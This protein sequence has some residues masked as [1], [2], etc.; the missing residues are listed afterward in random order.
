MTPRQIARKMNTHIAQC[1]TSFLAHLVLEEMS[2]DALEARVSQMLVAESSRLSRGTLSS[3]G[4]HILSY[5]GR[6]CLKHFLE[7][8]AN[9]VWGREDF[10]YRAHHILAPQP[11]ARNSPT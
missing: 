10:S 2:P 3:V 9:I 11:E 4:V 8:K 1:P 6:L 5:I 7:R